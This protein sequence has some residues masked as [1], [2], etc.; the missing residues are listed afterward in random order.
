[1]PTLIAGVRNSHGH[2]PPDILTLLQ[3][4][5]KYSD[6]SSNKVRGCVG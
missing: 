3:D 2:C 5:I 1:M 4:I 6:N